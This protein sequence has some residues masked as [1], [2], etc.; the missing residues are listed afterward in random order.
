MTPAAQIQASIEMIEH[1][2]A[3]WAQDRR[4][5]VDALFADYFK[6]RRYIG[7]KDCGA[8]DRRDSL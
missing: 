7:S 8:I 3:I 2:Q 4:A 1:V 5:P 6:G